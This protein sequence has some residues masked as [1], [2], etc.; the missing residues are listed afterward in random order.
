MRSRNGSAARGITRLM[1]GLIAT[2]LLLV[3]C[4]FSGVGRGPVLRVG[5]APTYPPV[6]F[7]NESEIVGIEADLARMVGNKIGRRLVFQRYAFP[8]LLDALERGDVDVVMS[9]LSVTPERSARVHFTDSYMQVGQLAVIRTQDLARLGRIQ[10]IRRPETRVGYQRGTTGEVYVA[11]QLTRS[12]AFAFDSI[13]D[14]LRSLRA[15]RIDYFVHDS[16]TI[17]RLTGDPAHRDLIGLYRPLT[18]ERLAWAVR[19]NDTELARRLNEALSSLRNE[20]LLEPILNRWIPVR[21]RVP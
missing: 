14:G 1:V 13:D 17:W 20:G 8:D 9:G 18:D 6:V 4:A 11:N 15:G 21:V 5:T 12:V 3:G 10:W 2:G 7:E 16:P 19:R